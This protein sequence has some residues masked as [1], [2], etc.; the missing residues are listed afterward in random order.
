MNSSIYDCVIHFKAKENWKPMRKVLTPM[1][2]L[3][4]LQSFIPI[5][6]E[7]SKTFVEELNKEVGQ[8]QFNILPYANLSALC[9]ICGEY[10]QIFNWK[11]VNH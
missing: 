3:K 11:I 7:K 10:S 8:P 1:L 2:N 4:M 6:N 9:S 5:F